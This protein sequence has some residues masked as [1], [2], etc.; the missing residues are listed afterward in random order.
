MTD[1]H[2][3]FNEATATLEPV[4]VPARFASVVPGEVA[5]DQAFPSDHDGAIAHFRWNG[6]FASVIIDFLPGK[7]PLAQC[8]A[9][10]GPGMTCEVQPDGSALPSFQERQPMVDGGVTVR[11]VTLFDVDGW[12]VAVLS[13]NAADA[14]SEVYAVAPSRRCRSS[15][16]SRPP[17]AR[18]GSADGPQC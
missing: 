3:Y 2:A 7:P 11:S 4:D 16:S 6:A 10:A 12:Q 1:P 9:S 15:S 17:T 13:Y 8:Q 5:G 18:S 14:K